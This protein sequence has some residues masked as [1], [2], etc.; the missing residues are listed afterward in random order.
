LIASLK[1]G[2]AQEARAMAGGALRLRAGER[3]GVGWR[4]GATLTAG[5]TCQRPGQ[6]EKGREAAGL[7]WAASGLRRKERP[8]GLIASRLRRKGNGPGEERPAGLKRKKER[9]RRGFEKF[10]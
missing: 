4:W 2:E 6:K 9:E 1:E 10:F 3:K 8:D 5:P 7:R